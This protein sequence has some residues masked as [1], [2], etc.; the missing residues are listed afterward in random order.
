MR[1]PGHASPGGKQGVPRGR[2]N[3]NVGQVQPAEPS[4]NGLSIFPTTFIRKHEQPTSFCS[5]QENTIVAAII[6]QNGPRPPGAFLVA[7]FD[8]MPHFS[9]LRT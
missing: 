8:F 9:I 1:L 4:H 6:R 5:R 2:T 7:T 3:K